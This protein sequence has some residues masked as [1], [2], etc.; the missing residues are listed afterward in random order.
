MGEL[1]ASY[2]ET[3]KASDQIRPVDRGLVETGRQI[4]AQIDYAVENLT[5]QDLTKAL[6]LSPHLVNI[7]R[8]LLATPAA[9]HA[10][11][12]KLD[13]PTGEDTLTKLRR[14]KGRVA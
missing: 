4:A 5:G 10:A 6:Y 13:V 11:G 8:E 3:V 2:E 1:L 14:T 7:L 12:I 9:R